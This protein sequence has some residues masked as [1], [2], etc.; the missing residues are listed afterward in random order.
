VYRP[1]K[2]IPLNNSTSKKLLRKSFKEKVEA[3]VSAMAAMS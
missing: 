2:A 1:V 3:A